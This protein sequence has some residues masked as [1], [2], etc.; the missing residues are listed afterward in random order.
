MHTKVFR[1]KCAIACIS[2]YEIQQEQ[3]DDLMDRGI[4]NKCVRERLNKYSKG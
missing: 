1:S 2:Y 3:K 4:D